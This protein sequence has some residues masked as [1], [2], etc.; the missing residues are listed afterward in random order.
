MEHLPEGLRED[1]L[2]YRY[3]FTKKILFLGE[4]FFCFSHQ[5]LQGDKV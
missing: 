4:I 3:L 5:F 2:F 1:T